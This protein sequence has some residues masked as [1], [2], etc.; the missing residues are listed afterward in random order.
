MDG[1]SFFQNVAVAYRLG[2]ARTRLKHS[3][4]LQ[5]WKAS[6]AQHVAL[7]LAPYTFDLQ[8]ERASLMEAGSFSEW[9]SRLSAAALIS[10]TVSRILT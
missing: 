6:R 3:K 4:Q 1:G 5:G 2:S 10:A 9:G 7:A 8:N